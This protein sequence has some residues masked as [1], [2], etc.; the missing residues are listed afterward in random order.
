MARDDARLMLERDPT[1]ETTRGEALRILLYVFERDA[2][3]RLLR[4]G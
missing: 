1:L 3:A 4:S 2:A